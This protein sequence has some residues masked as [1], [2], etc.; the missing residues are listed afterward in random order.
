MTCKKEI[1]YLTDAC[2]RSNAAGYLP[3]LID[4]PCLVDEWLNRHGKPWASARIIPLSGSEKHHTITVALGKFR[5]ICMSEALLEGRVCGCRGI[6]QIHVQS[7]VGCLSE[8]SAPFCGECGMPCEA[9]KVT[10]YD[11]GE[12][13]GAPCLIPHTNTVSECCNTENLYQDCNLEIEWDG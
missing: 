10:D 13:W 11:K 6:K 7:D 1:V 2:S 5:I 9:N 3:S 8:E 12:A 4:V